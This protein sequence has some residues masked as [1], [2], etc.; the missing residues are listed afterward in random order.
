LSDDEKDVP[1]DLKRYPAKMPLPQELHRVIDRM[2]Q[3]WPVL[4]PVVAVISNWRA[5]AIG[6]AVYV[7]FRSGDIVSALDTLTGVGP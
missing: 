5:W 7:Y 3:A 1:D 6:A 2:D 4:R